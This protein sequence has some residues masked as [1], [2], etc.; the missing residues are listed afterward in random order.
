MGFCTGA[1]GG[2]SCRETKVRMRR[3]F[4]GEGRITHHDIESWRSEAAVVNLNEGKYSEKIRP[5]GGKIGPCSG[6]CWA[7]RHKSE[8]FSKT[9]PNIIAS[10]I[11]TTFLAA[12]PSHYILL[13]FTQ[14]YTICCKEPSSA[15]QDSRLPA[16]HGS[17]RHYVSNPPSHGQ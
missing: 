3:E 8:F 15:P 14:L 4:I 1:E 11:S 7:I 5:R 9:L 12:Q 2:A 17:L 16:K 10:H 6:G 13:H